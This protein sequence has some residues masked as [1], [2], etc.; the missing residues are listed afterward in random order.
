VNR[1]QLAG[2]IMSAVTALSALDVDKDLVSAIQHSTSAMAEGRLPLIDE[3][4]NTY[5]CRTCGRI[6]LNKP[7]AV[8]PTCH[9][10]P[11]TFL[12][13]LPVYWLEAFNPSQAIEN[14]RSTPSEVED[15]IEGLE[16]SVLLQKSQDG[17]WSI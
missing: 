8:C 3:A 14:L 1:S 10:H 11:V 12:P 4:P 9:A 13:F 17:E 16:E 5:V 2:E 6:E 15:C 7:T